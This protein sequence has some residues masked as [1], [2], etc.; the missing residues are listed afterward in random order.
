MKNI[1]LSAD[2]K[3]IVEARAYAQAHD[4]TLNKLIRDYMRCLAGGKSGTDA[5]DEFASLSRDRA[6]ESADGF[7]FDRQSVH[8]RGR[9]E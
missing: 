4:T 9:H 3:L 1:T 8:T 6:G 5:A 7:R 2:E